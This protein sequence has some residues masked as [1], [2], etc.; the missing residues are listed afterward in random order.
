MPDTIAIIGPDLPQQVFAA[1]CIALTVWTIFQIALLQIGFPQFGKQV[2][3][4]MAI[5]ATLAWVMP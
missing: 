1:T 2:V 4:V 3:S 5:F